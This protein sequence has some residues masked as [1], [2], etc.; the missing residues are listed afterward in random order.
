M[1]ALP[2]EFYPIGTGVAPREE[3]P[4]TRV[5]HSTQH[6]HLLCRHAHIRFA[7]LCH[8]CARHRRRNRSPGNRGAESPTLN[9]IKATGTITFGY[10]DNAVPFSYKNRDGR[11]KGYSVELCTRVAG[12]IQNELG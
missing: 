1:A 2:A 10:R 4:R 9:R 11:I 12:A 8:R 6:P 3:R 5:L 7:G